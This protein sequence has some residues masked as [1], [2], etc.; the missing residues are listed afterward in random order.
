MLLIFAGCAN[1][2]YR[3]EKTAGD[4]SETV[5]MKFDSLIGARD[6][7]SVTAEARF[8]DGADTAQMN[9]RLHLGPPAEFV[10]AATVLQKL[11]DA[12]SK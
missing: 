9:F 2:E 6:G 12:K 3:F 7:D 10:S 1:S 11:V 5:P 4:K 8:S